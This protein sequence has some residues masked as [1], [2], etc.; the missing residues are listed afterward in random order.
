MTNTLVVSNSTS[1]GV[2]DVAA[3]A[4]KMRVTG[5]PSIKFSL[6]DYNNGVENPLLET[7]KIVAYTISA[8]NATVYTLTATQPAG[9]T[10][11]ILTNFVSYLSPS[12]GATAASICA[13]L[14][15][16]FNYQA[17]AIGMGVVAS[18]D[19]SDNLKLTASTGTPLF[20]VSGVSSNLTLRTGA[21]DPLY[22][23]PDSTPATAL[24]GTTTVT[25][26]TASAHGLKPGNTIKLTTWATIVLTYKGA[27]A[28]STNGL[29]CRVATVPSP[30]TF[31]LEAVVGSVGANSSTTL[32]IY[33]VPQYAMGTPAAV[34]AALLADGQSITANALY[35]YARVFI[36]YGVMGNAS[37]NNMS[38][39]NTLTF[40]FPQ[41]LVAS[42]YTAQN[43]TFLSNLKDLLT[44][45]GGTA[46]PDIISVNSNL[47]QQ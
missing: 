35:N 26:T 1:L 3:V 41:S 43:A 25:V 18:N 38:S 6:I 4:G 20:S 16:T 46:N 23:A 2:A 28:S 45:G 5:L 10:G 7:A 27:A 17:T 22:L 31:T 36:E 32:K 44:G 14:V 47:T 19:G 37:I 29:I 8:A 11:Q 40:Y 34:D 33:K 30:T 21:N 24:S 42:P 39:N 13:A 12:T 9:T 15:E